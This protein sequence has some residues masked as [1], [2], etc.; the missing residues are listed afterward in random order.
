VRMCVFGCASVSACGLNI[1]NTV[2]ARTYVL[3]LNDFKDGKYTS[4]RE[5]IM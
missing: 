2:T 1:T 4:K 3:R 5:Q